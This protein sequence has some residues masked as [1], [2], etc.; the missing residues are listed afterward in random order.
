MTKT[1]TITID[2]I[3]ALLDVDKNDVENGRF[4]IADGTMRLYDSGH[5]GF[6]WIYDGGAGGAETGLF[7][8]KYDVMEWREANADAIIQHHGSLAMTTEEI[9]DL[10]Q[11]L[12]GTVKDWDALNESQR[13]A[14]SLEAIDIIENTLSNTNDG[15]FEV[16]PWDSISGRPETFTVNH[17]SAA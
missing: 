2:Q 7:Q 14:W 4:E 6:R 8:S 9:D 13:L 17:R 3:A 1:D 10:K 16:R 5:G 15:S 12:A 11:W